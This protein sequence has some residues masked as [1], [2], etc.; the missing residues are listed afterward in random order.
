M[1]LFSLEKLFGVTIRESATDGSDFTNPDADY[2]RLFLGEDGQLHVKDSAGAVTSIGAGAIATDAIWDAAGDLAVGTGANTAGKLTVGAD[3]TVLTVSP[4]THV[5]VWSAPAGGGSDLVQVSSGMGS[6]VIPGLKGSP[7]AV[8]G[9]PSGYDD[10]FN[11]LSGW[12]VLGTLDT[13]NVT[14]FPS[15]WHAKRVNGAVAADGIYKTA[16]STPFTVTCKLAASTVW[17]GA[18]YNGAGLLLTENAPGKLCVYALVSNTAVVW[19]S[20]YRWTNRTTYSSTTDISLGIATAYPVPKYLRVIVTAS[21]N[22]TCDVSYDGFIWTTTHAGADSLLTVANVGL[23]IG[24]AAAAGTVEA[25][26]DW[27]RF[28]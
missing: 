22:I 8:P 28:T 5:P 7:D 18:N 12:T 25:V 19:T 27:I 6:V 14:D 26:F 17:K 3:S 9:S 11:A 23:Y 2:R 10:E 16:P 13:S 1:G 24:D 21:N 15:H 4:S 20:L